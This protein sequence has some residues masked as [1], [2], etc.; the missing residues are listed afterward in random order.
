MSKK[1]KKLKKAKQSSD[2][3]SDQQQ[4]N[5]QQQ[6]NDSEFPTDWDVEVYR[7]EYESEEHWLLRKRFMEVHKDKFPE[8]KLVCLA[9]VFTNM[10]FMGCKYP[11]ETMAMVA[12]LS[13]EVAKEFREGRANRLKRTF[14][15]A[16]DAAEARAKGRRSTQQT[17]EG[18]NTQQL[19]GQKRKHFDIGGDNMDEMQAPPA[20]KT[21][22]TD[23]FAGLK[24]NR[25]IV[26]LNGG[27]Q[28]LQLS[29]QRSNVLYEEKEVPAEN[30]IKK[31]EVRLNNQVVAVATGENLKTAKA[32]AFNK[33][34]ET[35]QTECYSIKPGRKTIKIEKD[36]NKAV[37]EVISSEVDAASEDKKLDDNNKGFRMMKMMGWSGGGLGSKKQGREDPV[38]YLFKSNRSGL[39]KEDCKMDKQYFKNILRNYVESEDIRE[40][41]F[42][43]TFTKE[44]RALLHEIAKNFNLRSS[45]YGQGE[46]RRLIITKKTITDNQILHEVLINKNPRFMDRYLVQVPQSKSELFPDHTETLTL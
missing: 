22:Q 24:Y 45:S 18:Q 40:L 35:L 42:E 14:V 10:E 43:P 12:E 21:P 39:G 13:K 38:A 27:R 28:C 37:C 17:N 33:A 16:S 30:N 11:A 31:V 44:E 29:A 6:Q 20:K 15:A 5:D 8:D 4:T 46:Q 19:Q 9:Q 25:F 41:Q 23:L 26:F 34:L 32:N 1:D 7:R 2:T 3:E 36:N